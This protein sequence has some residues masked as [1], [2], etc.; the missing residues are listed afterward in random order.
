MSVQQG[1]ELEISEAPRLCVAVKDSHA[2]D[3]CIG[4]IASKEC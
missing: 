4:T 3:P 2:A 1:R